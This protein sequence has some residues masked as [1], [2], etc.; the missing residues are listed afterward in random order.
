M[1]SLPPHALIV[2]TVLL[3]VVV[4]LDQWDVTVCSGPLKVTVLSGL[5]N[6][7]LIIRHLT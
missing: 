6:R 4:I 1:F 2:C 7:P 3:A 5:M